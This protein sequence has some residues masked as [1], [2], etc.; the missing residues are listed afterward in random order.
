MRRRST[1]ARV[2]ASSAEK[3]VASWERSS[4]LTSVNTPSR[5]TRWGLRAAPKRWKKET[6]P[7]CA[8]GPAPG[9]SRRR[10]VRMARRRIRSGAD[11][12]GYDELMNSIGGCD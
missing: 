10:V 6:A 8:S 2:P 9:L 5:T 1:E 3:W 12:P 11:A 7:I 4:P